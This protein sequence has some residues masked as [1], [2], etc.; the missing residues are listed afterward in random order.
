VILFAL[1]SRLSQ[2]SFFTAE[3]V[4]LLKED[5]LI[6][7]VNQITAKKAYPMNKFNK[8]FGQIL[9]LF[10]HS[11]FFN[12]LHETKSFWGAKGFSCRAQWRNN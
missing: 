10:P 2:I 3:K 5:K 6:F 12:L 4:Y 7:K 8:I 9:N 11:E 1:S